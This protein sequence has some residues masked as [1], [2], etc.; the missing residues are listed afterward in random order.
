MTER[1]YYQ[2]ATYKTFAAHIVE[3]LTHDGQPAVVLDR[4]AFIPPEVA[5]PMTGASWAIDTLKIRRYFG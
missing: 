4:T 5:S 3:R 2:D 1:L